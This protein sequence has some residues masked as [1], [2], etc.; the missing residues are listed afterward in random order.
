MAIQPP[1][2]GTG[3]Y[4]PGIIPA[5]TWKAG[6]APT[7]Q[8]RFGAPDL[9]SEQAPALLCISHTGGSGSLTVEQ[10]TVKA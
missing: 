5:L 3:T 10:P 2:D 1:R 9:K 6:T 7:H 4:G 8:G